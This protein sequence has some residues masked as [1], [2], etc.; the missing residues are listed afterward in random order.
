MTEFIAERI[1]FIAVLVTEGCRGFENA[2]KSC[3]KGRKSAGR[4]FKME[5]FKW[6]L[7]FFIQD[8]EGLK[9]YE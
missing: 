6:N 2:V 3:E 1:K 8:L 4:K 9:Q 5:S 7:N